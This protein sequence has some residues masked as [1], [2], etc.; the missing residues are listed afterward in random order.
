MFR[1]RDAD[2]SQ[3]VHAFLRETLEKS[4]A[5]GPRAHCVR[6]ILVIGGN[7]ELGRHWAVKIAGATGLPLVDHSGIPF[8]HIPV[9]CQAF[10][11]LN[12]LL[13]LL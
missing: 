8:F 1:K 6:R 10:S 9:S 12:L 11:G 7:E 5:R 4:V 2:G 13:L 3:D